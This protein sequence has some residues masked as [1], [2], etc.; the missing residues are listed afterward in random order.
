MIASDGRR[1]DARDCNGVG[2]HYGMDREGRIGDLC[3]ECFALYSVDV[4]RGG[5]RKPSIDCQYCG[6]AVYMLP[7]QFARAMKEIDNREKKRVFTPRF[8]CQSCSSLWSS[9]ILSRAS[10]STGTVVF[11]EAM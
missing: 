10:L 6:K 7:S 9:Y 1:C 11:A 3:E 2:V 8:V 5:I 4:L